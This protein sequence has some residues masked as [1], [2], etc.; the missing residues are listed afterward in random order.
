MIKI[1]IPAQDQPDDKFGVNRNYLEFISE[2]GHPIIILPCKKEEF[3][4]NYKIDVLL[5]PGGADVNT[6]RY[7]NIPMFGTYNPNIYLEHFDKEILPI[8]IGNIPIFGICRGLQT[9]NVTFGGT[10]K[11]LI[12]HPVSNYETDKI[13]DVFLYKNG[14][15]PVWDNKKVNKFGVN[16][17]HHQAIDKLANNFEIEAESEYGGVIEAISDYNKRIFAVQ[18]HPERLLDSY[19]QKMFYSILK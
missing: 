5:L 1:G 6:Q 2:F 8:L 7:T 13:H 18:W 17:F 4:D 9:L 16:S 15:R 3:F 19:S 10:L 14:I 11:N 12:W